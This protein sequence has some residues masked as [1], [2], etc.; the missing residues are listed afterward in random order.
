MFNS[1]ERTALHAGSLL[2]PIITDISRDNEEKPHM[3]RTAKD[4][5]SLATCITARA[6]KAACL[7]SIHAKPAAHQPKVDLQSA[8]RRTVGVSL[9]NGANQSFAFEVD[10][11]RLG[12]GCWC[13]SEISPPRLI[14]PCRW[15]SWCWEWCPHWEAIARGCLMSDISEGWDWL[16]WGE[17]SNLDML[18]SKSQTSRGG[19]RGIL[20]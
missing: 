20:C 10:A 15:Q 3:G 11:G 16:V 1:R 8:A 13:L 18:L 7:G 17:W 19:R 6:R 5:A 9:P 2:Y 4:N 12:S 14:S